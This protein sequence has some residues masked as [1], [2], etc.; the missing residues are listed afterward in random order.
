MSDIIQNTINKV[1]GEGARPTK[2][3]CQIF[4]PK[5]LL[6]KYGL[7]YNDLDIFGFTGSFPGYTTETLDYK[8]KGRNIPLKG[9]QNYE[10]KWTATF[11][12]DENHKIRQ[13]FLDWI[14]NN[15]N[16]HFY[17]FNESVEFNPILL[18]IYQM[19]YELERD[20]ALYTLVN[21]FPTNISS[22]EL[23]Y[24]NLNQI[25]SFSVEFSYSHFE[26]SIIERSGLTSN[27][28]ANKIQST[29]QNV[30]NKVFSSIM[31]KAKEKLLPVTDYIENKVSGLFSYAQ[32]KMSD[33]LG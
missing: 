2:F 31:N 10:Q 22:I 17:E 14:E 30:T 6:S 18:H 33:F 5:T 25:E 23:S 27:E 8:F 16:E 1:V 12:N 4:L 15:Q 7:T 3:K 21:V 13:L 11:Y 29:I 28:I 26:Y 24:E 19:N 20:T 9:V 32:D